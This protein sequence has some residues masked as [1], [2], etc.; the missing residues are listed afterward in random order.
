MPNEII[1]KLVKPWAYVGVL[2]GDDTG[3]CWS[4]WV[5]TELDTYQSHRQ[6]WWS[7]GKANFEH[8]NYVQR[9]PLSSVQDETKM[10][11]LTAQRE[12]TTQRETKDTISYI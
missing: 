2:G 5:H 8:Y 7:L 6:S 9:S 11:L 12:S 4:S 3:I 10:N 1:H